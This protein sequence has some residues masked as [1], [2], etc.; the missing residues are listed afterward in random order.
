M[1]NAT[2]ISRADGGACPPTPGNSAALQPIMKDNAARQCKGIACHVDDANSSAARE[3]LRTNRPTRTRNISGAIQALN[4]T[5]GG[6]RADQATERVND[7]DQ[8]G[9]TRK[10][11]ARRSR[12][13]PSRALIRSNERPRHAL[14][15]P[16]FRITTAF[17]DAPGQLAIEGQCRHRHDHAVGTIGRWW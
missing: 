11:A 6:N 16:A 17:A 9:E 1:R 2:R 7:E 14:I 3:R 13:V 10:T 8:G 5:S 12:A 4:R 15:S